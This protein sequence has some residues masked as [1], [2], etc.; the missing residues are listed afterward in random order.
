MQPPQKSLSLAVAWML[1]T[2]VS[3]LLMSIAGRE[4]SA[5]PG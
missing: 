5:S 1:A 2:I 4:L 3:F